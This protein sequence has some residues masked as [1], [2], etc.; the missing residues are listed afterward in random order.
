MKWAVVSFSKMRRLF[1]WF[2]GRIYLSG[3]RKLSG[4]ILMRLRI[5]NYVLMGGW[6]VERNKQCFNWEPVRATAGLSGRW[7]EWNRVMN[8]AARRDVIIMM[9]LLTGREGVYR[10]L[11]GHYCSSEYSVCNILLLMIMKWEGKGRRKGKGWRPQQ[12]SHFNCAQWLIVSW[13]V[14]GVSIVLTGLKLY[15]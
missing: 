4:K 1:A 13:R 15:G 9:L 3:F 12:L 11:S 2:P 14:E 5:I 8:S 7:V 6:S 10:Q